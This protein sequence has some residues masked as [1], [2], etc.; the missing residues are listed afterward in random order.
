MKALHGTAIYTGGGFYT[1]IGE[2][3]NDYWFCGNNDWCAIFDED[4]RTWDND[5]NGLACFWNDWCEM[6]E[7]KDFDLKEVYAM[8]E[9]FCK[10]LDA[11]E[12]DITKGYEKFS[13]YLPGEVTD[14]ID[15]SYFD[16]SCFFFIIPLDNL[17]CQVVL[18]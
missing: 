5:N 13:N 9:D 4:T 11:N 18:P 14:H 7:V 3:D 16:L 2:L 1:V 10:R 6:H 15:F 17:S 8:L 12:P